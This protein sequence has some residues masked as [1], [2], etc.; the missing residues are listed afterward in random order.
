MKTLKFVCP[1]CKYNQ[2]EVVMKNAVVSQTIKDINE[3][4]DFEYGPPVINDG[5]TECFQCISCGFIPKDKGG[6]DI[7]YN[8]DL[9]EWIEKNCKQD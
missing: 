7:D 3:D 5:E 2:L 6:K 9:V 8:D 4:G 1:K